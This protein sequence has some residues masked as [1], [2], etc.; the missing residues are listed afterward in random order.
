MDPHKQAGF[1]LLIIP[2][3]LGIIVLSTVT[4]AVISSDEEAQ[5]KANEAMAGFGDLVENMPIL[6]DSF[7]SL[8]NQVELDL[9]PGS[10]S[11]AK[12]TP[13]PPE[14]VFEPQEDPL[15]FCLVYS[16]Y[17]TGIAVNTT[18]LCDVNPIFCTERNIL[19][20]QILFPGQSQTTQQNLPSQLIQG[21]VNPQR[22]PISFCNLNPSF[23]TTGVVDTTL[24]CGQN[25]T[26]CYQWGIMSGDNI[27]LQIPVHG[28]INP[29]QNPTEFCKLNPLLCS[30][31]EVNTTTLCGGNPAFCATNQIL[32]GQRIIPPQQFE[33]NQFLNPLLDPN[34]NP[35][36]NPNINPMV[37]PKINPYANPNINPYVNPNIFPMGPPAGIPQQFNPYRSILGR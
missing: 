1:S 4:A 32:P 16:D 28:N 31:Y 33:Q 9:T 10:I 3:I 29:K 2:V 8:L 30:G 36:A 23:C 11:E 20:G 27:P 6:G 15:N 24:L 17:C 37:N 14:V 35:M 18:S 25:Q 5:Q 26:L 12:P 22:D 7:G 21:D 19:P 34:I 13:L